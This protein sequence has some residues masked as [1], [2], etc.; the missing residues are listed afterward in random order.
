MNVRLVYTM[1]WPAGIWFDDSLQI[2]NYKIHLNL[3]TNTSNHDDHVVA[4]GRINHFIYQELTNTVFI[5]D[6]HQE[7][8]T[9]L[10]EAGIKTTVLPEVPIDQIIGLALF[11][12]LNAICEK[13]I[14]VTELSVQSLLGDNVQYLHNNEETAGPFFDNGWWND[15]TPVHCSRVSQ[16]GKQKIIKLARTFSWDDLKFSWADEGKGPD[17]QV[18]F[19]K[20]N[21]DES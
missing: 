16:R 19:V 2:N 15:P 13:R 4:L 12:K 17:G 11:N 10:T 18:V 8:I 9:K 21:K 5:H 3:L 1:D 14:I 20:F 7:Q 6:V